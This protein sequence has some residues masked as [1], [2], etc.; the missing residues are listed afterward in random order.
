MRIMFNFKFLRVY[1]EG[2]ELYLE[3][4]WPEAKFKLET[5]QRIKGFDDK[6][7]QQVLKFMALH[8]FIAPA[9]WAGHSRIEQYY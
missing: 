4:H 1:E 7:T 6:P 2:I 8:N 3:G 9:E 5:V